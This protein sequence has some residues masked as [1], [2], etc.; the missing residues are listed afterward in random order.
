MKVDILDRRGTSR[1]REVEVYERKYSPEEKKTILF[2][3]APPDVRGTG[4][5]EFKH[6]GRPADQWLYLPELKRVRQITPRARDES[7]VGTDLTFNEIDLLD[8]MLSW[9]E[10]DASAALVGNEPIDG[11]ECWIIDQTPHREDIGYER[12]RVWLG[13]TDLVPRRT[14]LFEGG[15]TPRKRIQQGDV[16]LIGVIPVSHRMEV[17][18]VKSGTKTILE[19]VS[20]RFD[21]G[22][23]EELFT[24]RSLE[25]GAR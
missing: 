19:S 25:R 21:Q 14:E 15:D 16:R 9:S 3:L 4:F 1:A 12:I 2:F 13:R 17:E 10:R 5:L 22:L 20:V 6:L 11:T 24:E 18:T 23:E 8:E 7:F